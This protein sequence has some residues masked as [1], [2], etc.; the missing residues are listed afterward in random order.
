MNDSNGIRLLW[1][2]LL[3]YALTGALVIATE[4]VMGKIAEYFNLLVS[5]MSNTFAFL[6]AGILMAIFLNA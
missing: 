6:N 1:I 2:S 4:M 5:S 3:S